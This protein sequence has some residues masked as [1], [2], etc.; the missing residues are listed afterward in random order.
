MRINPFPN[1][2]SN[3]K[4]PNH[5]LQEKSKSVWIVVEVWLV[6]NLDLIILIFSLSLESRG[7]SPATCQ[8]RCW[9]LWLPADQPSRWWSATD[10]S[11]RKVENHQFFWLYQIFW[12]LLVVV[13]QL[14]VDTILVQF[15]KHDG[16]HLVPCNYWPPSI[17]ALAGSSFKGSQLPAAPAER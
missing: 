11:C 1:K 16:G 13:C 14:P 9:L 6:I 10:P 5:C 4:W 12:L 3:S 15:L 8:C 2:W 7:V 17:S